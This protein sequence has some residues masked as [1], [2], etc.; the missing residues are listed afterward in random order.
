M[1]GFMI[2]Q[3]VFLTCVM[4]TRGRE[5]LRLHPGAPSCHREMWTN[6]YA[7]EAA[8]NQIVCPIK[9]IC[10]SGKKLWCLLKPEEKIQTGQEASSSERCFFPQRFSSHWFKFKLREDKTS[11]SGKSNIHT[12][13]SVLPRATHKRTRAQRHA[14]R[15]TEKIQNFKC[16]VTSCRP[17]ALLPLE[18]LNHFSLKAA[19]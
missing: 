15:S 11:L 18:Y 12:V 14:Q 10:Y 17:F 4:S 9:N 3:A 6:G 1:P 7:D 16:S 2:G 8:S 13:S 5:N 19:Y